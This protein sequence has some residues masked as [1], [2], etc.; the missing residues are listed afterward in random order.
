MVLC[1]ILKN[2]ISEMS[3]MK[4]WLLHI[5]PLLC[6]TA[7]YFYLLKFKGYSYCLD[8]HLCAN[9]IILSS[10]KVKCQVKL[11]KSSLFRLTLWWPQ[12]PHLSSYTRSKTFLGLHFVNATIVSH[13]YPMYHALFKINQDLLILNPYWY[14]S[15]HNFMHSNLLDN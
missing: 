13:S 8:A 3:G 4:V 9:W 7:C 11:G 12:K 2:D 6:T 15:C 14:S 10:S 5:H 1:F